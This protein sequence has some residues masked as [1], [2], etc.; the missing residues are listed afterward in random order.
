MKE[1]NYLDILAER[2]ERNVLFEVLR[3]QVSFFSEEPENIKIRGLSAR[4]DSRVRSDYRRYNDGDFPAYFDSRFPNYNVNQYED[5][6]FICEGPDPDPDPNPNSETSIEKFLRNIIFNSHCSID[7]ILV[8]GQPHEGAARFRDYF[9]ETKDYGEYTINSETLEAPSPGIRRFDL[10]IT[11]R[12]NENGTDNREERR[13]TL[14]QLTNMADHQSANLAEEDINFLYRLCTTINPNRLIAHCAA[15]LGRS[16]TILFSFML[17]R[18]FRQIFMKSDEELINGIT[19]EL[20]ALRRVRPASIQQPQQLEQAIQLACAYKR[21]DWREFP[22]RMAQDMEGIPMICMI[23]SF[24]TKGADYNFLR[25]EIIRQGN[26]IFSID[27]GVFPS[28]SYFPVNINASDLLRESEFNLEEFRR[29]RNRA[30]AVGAV[31]LGLAQQIGS[32]YKSTNFKRSNRNG[33][34]Q[35]NRCHN[36]GDAMFAKGN[37]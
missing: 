20:A 2:F 23:G 14:Y 3:K 6:Y 10:T 15:G 33:R 37:A 4:N 27:I 18:R 30:E 13:I 24:D 1:I 34:H 31:K 11:Q 17:F 29:V 26:H 8:I 19:T 12:V 22:E 25:N 9:T 5:G 21:I 16:P 36:G 32:L 28:D 7:T 35:R